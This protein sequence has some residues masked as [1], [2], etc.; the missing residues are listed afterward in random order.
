MSQIYYLL[1]SVGPP[2]G[3]GGIPGSGGTSDFDHWLNGQPVLGTVSDG[4][5]G[6]WANGEPVEQEV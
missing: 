5:T 4:S 1:L 2:G 6:F 3:G